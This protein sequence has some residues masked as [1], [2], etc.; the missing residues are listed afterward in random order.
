MEN[1]Y[2]A[3]N[4]EQTWDHA[5]NDGWKKQFKIWAAAPVVQKMWE[6]SSETYGIRF[7]YFC[8]RNLGLPRRH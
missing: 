4:F 8:E 7:R 1:I 3:L 6:L 2:L 5:D